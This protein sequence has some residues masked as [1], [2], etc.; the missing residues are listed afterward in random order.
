[1]HP[2]KDSTGTGW[3]ISQAMIAVGSGQ[4]FGKGL[5]KGTQGRLRF[6]PEDHTDFIFAVLSEELGFIGSFIVLFLYFLMIGG[7]LK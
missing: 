7:G 3:Q 1:M 5:L 2:E 6:L 4:F